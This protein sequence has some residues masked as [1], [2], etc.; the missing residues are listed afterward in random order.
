VSR[1]CSFQATQLSRARGEKIMKRPGVRKCWQKREQTI[2]IFNDV[3]LAIIGGEIKPAFVSAGRVPKGREFGLR[4]ADCGA[5]IAECGLR[6][7]RPT[8]NAERRTPEVQRSAFSILV[9][10]P[11]TSDLRASEFGVERWTL[12][13]GRLL[14]LSNRR[15]SSRFRPLSELYALRSRKPTSDL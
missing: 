11:L 15:L 3:L 6:S 5:R 1:S 2:S 4:I 7:K 8:P 9:F 13:V 12:S 10:R 14:Q